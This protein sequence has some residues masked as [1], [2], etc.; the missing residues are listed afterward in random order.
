M[1]D[2]KKRA[3]YDRYGHN[4]EGFNAGQS[5]FDYRDQNFS[6]FGF[7]FDSIFN[8]FFRGETRQRARRGSDLRYD[9]EI[10]LEEA[11]KGTHKTIEL[12]K[13]ETCETCRGTGAQDKSDL[14]QCEACQGTGAER[15]SRR[16]AFGIFTS[17]SVCSKCR[18]KGSI[19][20]NACKACRGNG[21]VE[22]TRRIEVNIPAG[23]DDENRLRIAGEGE[24]GEKGVSAGDLY[25]VIYVKQHRLFEREGTDIHIELSLTFVQAAL[26]AE[27]E[28]P[29]LDGKAKLKIP[30]GTQPGTIFR[31]KGKGIPDPEY[32]GVGSENV[33][34]TVEVPS[35]LSA[36]QK[37][38]L[39]EF[40]KEG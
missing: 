18:G 28:V 17:A 13:L 24:A 7:D 20:K 3:Q 1:A 5:G 31:M 2:E 37:K 14:R 9:L 33:K 8:Q 6:E 11:A 15:I 27:I 22:K 25:I 23:V 38:L 34:V 4:A 12:E 40:E 21:R 36:K 30:A 19:I 10:T 26:G 39:E 35:K 29:T 32:G 16:T